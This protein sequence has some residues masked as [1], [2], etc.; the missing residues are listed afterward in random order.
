MINK[1]VDFEYIPHF[2]KLFSKKVVKD[3]LSKEKSEILNKLLLN[4]KISFENGTTY[5]NIFEKIY[6]IFIDKYPYEYVYK[7]QL[8]IQLLKK[9]YKSEH[10]FLQEVPLYN[11]IVDILVVNGRTTAY[12]IKTEFDSFYRLE[13]QL[14]SYTKVFD[15]VFVV[16]SE[17]FENKIT[18]FLDNNEFNNVGVQIFSNN[19]IK[20]IKQ[21]KINEID[22]S[23]Y[24]NIINQSELKKLN[25]TFENV[26]NLEITKALEIYRKILKSRQKNGNELIEKVPDSMKSLISN[27]HLL[28]WQKEKLIK[29]LSKNYSLI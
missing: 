10:I 12:E 7:N 25:L 21:A 20:Q 27:M 26:E 16:T 19:K 1:E 28:S 24:R 29:K 18:E 4:S 3:I 6:N 15:R 14:K 5:F 2:S 23:N 17:K 11:N 9:E 22:I 8:L 13:A